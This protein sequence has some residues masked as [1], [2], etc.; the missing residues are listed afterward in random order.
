VEV[1]VV[2]IEQL[3]RVISHVPVLEVKGVVEMVDLL[4][5]LVQPGLRIRVVEVVVRRLILVTGVTGVLV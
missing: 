5:V 4:M 2:Q 3:H 1:V